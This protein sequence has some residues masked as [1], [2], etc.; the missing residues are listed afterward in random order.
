M[1]KITATNPV[2][3]FLCLTPASAVTLLVG[4]SALAGA[5]DAVQ[6]D[7]SAATDDDAAAADIVADEPD[8]AIAAEE[9]N[10]D[11]VATDHP[12]ARVWLHAFRRHLAGFPGGA[13]DV[14][15]DFA[16]A[17]AEQGLTDDELRGYVGRL[18]TKLAEDLD[19]PEE[20]PLEQPV[21]TALL[22]DHA[23]PAA[24][25]NPPPPPQ[26][27]NCNN[28]AFDAAGKYRFKIEG[29]QTVGCSSD[30]GDPSY[31]PCAQEE[32]FVQ[33]TMFTPNATPTSGLTNV[34]TG[35]SLMSSKTKEVFNSG[36]TA[37]ST[38]GSASG[39][40]LLVFRL[41]EKDTGYHDT[42]AL[43]DAKAASAA[44]KTQLDWNYIRSYGKLKSDLA[45]LYESLSR[46]TAGGDD[47]FPLQQ[48][49]GA[50]T[51]FW[52]ITNGC[53]KYLGDFPFAIP[54]GDYFG[55]AMRS[56]TFSSHWKLWLTLN[57]I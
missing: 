32:V 48:L 14:E 46:N 55:Y 34:E 7:L 54:D 42:N 37:P 25:T 43:T 10:A 45:A 33:W 39:D 15:Q 1:S 8:D 19:E 57:R 20:L 4:L 38:A 3:T 31:P 51:M 9:V 47:V 23:A 35:L 26:A 29:V 16:A 12:L 5:C 24:L 44:I 11:A 52:D 49:G 2:R 30:A 40:A 53:F 22:A 28:K 36:Y 17:L 41:F 50:E 21:T 56:F 27:G 13:S 6:D 18:S